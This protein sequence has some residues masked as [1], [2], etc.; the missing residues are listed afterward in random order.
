MTLTGPTPKTPAGWARKVPPVLTLTSMSVEA[1]EGSCRQRLEWLG[2]GP[3]EVRLHLAHR[4]LVHPG[5]VVDDVSIHPDGDHCCLGREEG[6]PD[7][8]HWLPAIGD[9]RDA[10]Q[11]RH[12]PR[13]LIVAEEVLPVLALR[14]LAIL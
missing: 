7:F 1:I 11:L 12:I 5:W 10:D 14:V 9:L 2:S 3:V 8:L 13:Q 4:F 6:D